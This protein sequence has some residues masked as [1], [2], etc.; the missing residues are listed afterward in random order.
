[1]TSAAPAATREPNPV[2]VRRSGAQVRPW[3]ARCRVH[4]ASRDAE[5]YFGPDGAVACN[6]LGV[7]NRTWELARQAAAGHVRAFHA[8]EPAR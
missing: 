3:E 7:G 2:R 5:P 1:M 8:A 4:R 6:T